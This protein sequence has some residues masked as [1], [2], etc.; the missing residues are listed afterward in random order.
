MGGAGA[1]RLL[2]AEAAFALCLPTRAPTDSLCARVVGM[3]VFIK[4]NLVSIKENKAERDRFLGVKLKKYIPTPF[5]KY[6]FLMI[7]V[8]LIQ[9]N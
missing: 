7:C 3:M 9:C 8:I 5:A 2:D 6:F 4:F 1:G